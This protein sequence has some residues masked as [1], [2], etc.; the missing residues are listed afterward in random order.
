LILIERVMQVVLL[1]IFA[2]AVACA[3]SL[4]S[5]AAQP[6]PAGFP[7][8]AEDKACA[9][10]A[11]QTHKVKTRAFWERRFSEPLEERIGAAPPA[12]IEFLNLDVIHQGI[13]ARPRESK[14]DPV[15]L[16]EVKSAI[17]EMPAPV[18]AL[19]ASRLAGIWFIDDIGGSGFSD[20][21]AWGKEHGAGFIVLDPSQLMKRRANEWASWK[22]STP[23]TDNEAWRIEAVI[24]DDA[25]NQRKGA[26]QYILLH[27]FAH[28]LATRGDIHPHWNKAPADAVSFWSRQPFFDLSWKVNKKENRYV[29]VF[30]A[31]FPRRANIRYYFGA[32]LAASEM[33]AAYGW[34]ETT[35]FPTLYA[36]TSP[37][38]D[39]AESFVTYVHTVLMKKPWAI[40]LFHNGKQVKEVRACWDQPR[41]AEK[42]KLLEAILRQTP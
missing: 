17:M 13:P 3:G 6:L 24:A 29:S 2:V 10:K 38:D 35:N 4:G 30:D 21:I 11:L 32:N 12:L 40:R 42:R 7:C 27:E 34:L 39:F 33:T 41:C 23:F 14:L 25:G 18:R 31:V 16:A 19:I 8:G 15:F 36:A 26:I 5:A 9:A 28:V 22:E 1:R 20:A 37:G